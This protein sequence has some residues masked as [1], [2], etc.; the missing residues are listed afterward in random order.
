MQRCQHALTSVAIG[1]MDQLPESIPPGRK[2]TEQCD[3]KLTTTRLDGR[4]KGGYSP[5]GLRVEEDWGYFQEF[6]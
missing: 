2:K 4:L 1:I 5:L 3:Y 6:Y